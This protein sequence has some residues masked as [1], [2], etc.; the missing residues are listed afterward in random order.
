MD[1]KEEEN[2]VQTFVG[3]K[4]VGVDA[5]TI[6]RE[7]T[8]LWAAASQGGDSGLAVIRFCLM[9][10]IAHAPD[11]SRMGD[12]TQT[13]AN[14]AAYYP[15]RT[16]ML[17]N[18]PGEGEDKIETSLA[19]HCRRPVGG[20]RP[21]CGEQINITAHGPSAAADLPGTV[22][23]LLVSDLPVILW[24]P[25]WPQA[26]L[27]EDY[28]V[29]QYP[30]GSLL[31]SA[32]ELVV[33]SITFPHPLKDLARLAQLHRVD[34]PAVAIN[35]LNWIRLTSWRQL[36]AQIFDALYLRPF[37]NALTSVQVHYKR[38]P[39]DANPNQAL[40]L[41]GWLASR[42]NWQAP[43]ENKSGDGV[44]SMVMTSSDDRALT[45]EVLN[46]RGD[47]VWP[48]DVIDITLR[49]EF[50]GHKAT[51]TLTRR[52][53]GEDTRRDWEGG[54]PPIAE[55]IITSIEVDGQN[56]I[57]RTVHI[58]ARVNDELLV[59]AL[60]NLGHDPAYEAALNIAVG[61]GNRPAGK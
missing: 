35:D 3:G 25:N 23:P 52:Y 60:G 20:G 10:L 18:Q 31:A 44:W 24:W 15:S 13:V 1:T 19:A 16:I 26:A 34:D 5:R 4:P 32:D 41:I 43:T 6:E 8:N 39:G 42:L 12:M 54:L 51:F 9:N 11:E 50:D 17:L 37:L 59:E 61:L 33:D 48:G 53:F 49:G 40:L 2:R 21:I 28:Q 36:T 22:I 14:I 27:T 56:K 55:H 45:V 38:G 58:G 46:G 29:E 7:L 57:E 47:G 30:F